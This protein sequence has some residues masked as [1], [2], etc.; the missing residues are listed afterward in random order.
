MPTICFEPFDNE[1]GKNQK[2]K[3]TSKITIK[4]K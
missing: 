3:E 1:K 2:E 4:H